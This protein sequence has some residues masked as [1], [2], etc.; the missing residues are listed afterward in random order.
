MAVK[1][2]ELN[3]EPSLKENQFS[4]KIYG[5]ASQIVPSFV[6]QLLAELSTDKG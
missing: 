3:L 1:T 4:S 6:A 5:P 2:I